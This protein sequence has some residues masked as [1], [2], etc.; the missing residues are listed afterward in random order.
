MG[1]LGLP[2]GDIIVII[3]LIA[4]HVLQHLDE[5]RE[6]DGLLFTNTF[7]LHDDKVIDGREER[8][9]LEELSL[10]DETLAPF[11]DGLTIGVSLLEHLLI[12]VVVDLSF[13]LDDL[14]V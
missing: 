14:R 1:N 6:V 13:R 12:E 8:V 5:R 3:R 11:D 2:K 9:N 7:G 4:S 10:P